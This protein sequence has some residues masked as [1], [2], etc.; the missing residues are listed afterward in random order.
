PGLVLLAFAL[1]PAAGVAAQERSSPPAQDQDTTELVFQR[2]VFTY[3]QFE[4]RNPFEPL[5]GAGDGGPRFEELALLGIILSPQ[6]PL[7][8]ALVATGVQFTERGG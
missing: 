8:V 2:E 3:P 6:P 4:R 5:V 1:V 7:S